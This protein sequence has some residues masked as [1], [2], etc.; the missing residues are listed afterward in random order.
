MISCWKEVQI[1]CD[2]NESGN[3]CFYESTEV[4]GC[5]QK[6]KTAINKFKKE[7]WDTENCICPNC[8]KF[9]NNKTID[10]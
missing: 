8:L 2:S 1:E 6:N 9:L 3:D 5:K 4:L 7:G 10:R